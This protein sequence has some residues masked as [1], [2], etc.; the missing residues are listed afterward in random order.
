[1]PNSNPDL[2]KKYFRDRKKRMKS[3][4]IC[5]NCQKEKAVLNRNSCEECLKQKRF[6]TLLRNGTAF[7][8]E[9]YEKMLKKQKGNCAICKLLMKRVCI[10]HCHKKMKVRGLLCNSCNLAIGL[11]KDDISIMKRAIKYIR[12]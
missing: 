4:G 3:L 5:T 10:D 8:K 11:L 6:G 9:S 1:M 7:S 2:R 12:K